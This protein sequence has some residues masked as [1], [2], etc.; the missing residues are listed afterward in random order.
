MAQEQQ[1]APWPPEHPKRADFP[2][3]EHYLE[4]V[5]AWRHTFG[6][7]LAKAKPQPSK[8]SPAR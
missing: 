2:S 4:A 3:E 8:A 5:S 6:R 7:V 1:K